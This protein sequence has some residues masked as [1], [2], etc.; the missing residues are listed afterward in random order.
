VKSTG[1]RS[2]PVGVVMFNLRSG[3]K[4]EWIDTDL[5]YWVEVG[6]ILYCKSY[7]WSSTSDCP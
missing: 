7:S 6:V 2:G 1:N 5:P 4:A 3:L